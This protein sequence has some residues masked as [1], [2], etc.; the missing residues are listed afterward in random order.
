VNFGFSF[1]VPSQAEIDNCTA[2]YN[3]LINWSL[4][5]ITVDDNTLE[6]LYTKNVGQDNIS[7]FYFENFLRSIKNKS[8]QDQVLKYIHEKAI[9]TSFSQSL[10]K[11]YSSTKIT[12]KQ[13]NKEI[14]RYSYDD[15]EFDEGINYFSFQEVQVFNN[16]LG[17]LL[18]NNN[19]SIISLQNKGAGSV[20]NNNITLMCLGGT[21]S[22]NIT[23]TKYEGVDETAI[24]SKM[25]LTYLNNKYNN[26]CIIQNLPNE[27]VI[28]RSGASKYIII[29]D[30]GPDT[31]KD[32]D[33]ATFIAYLY[34]ASTKILYEVNYF[35]NFSKININYSEKNRIFNSILYLTLMN[36]LSNNDKS[37]NKMNQSSS[38][39]GIPNVVIGKLVLDATNDN[40]NHKIHL[41]GTYTKG[42]TIT[43]K[44]LSTN[45]EYTMSANSDGYFNTDKIVPGDYEIS[46]IEI[47]VLSGPNHR[48]QYV[49]FNRGERFFTINA[50][51]VN[52]LGLIH[53]EYDG[54]LASHHIQLNNSY[55]EVMN[56]YSQNNSNSQFAPGDFVN[57]DFHE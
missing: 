44:N 27:G 21:N 39:K 22:L 32:I 57:I 46:K 16:Q 19:W 12:G 55:D 29:Y 47:V 17:L 41:D 34:N 37:S 18:L 23:L 7:S 11:L 43:I 52:N 33:C 56:I 54:D 42:M 14:V 6:S 20:D 1:A 5:K 38:T 9:D 15:K 25:P 26:K 50:N 31:I 45:K 49:T 35:I 8:I 51:K 4:G 36:Y 40:S 3:Y 48:D 24:E 53:W 30:T 10:E 13:G 28:S 2:M